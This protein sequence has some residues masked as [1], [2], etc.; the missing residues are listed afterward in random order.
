MAEKSTEEIDHICDWLGKL[1][2]EINIAFSARCALRIAPNL[3]AVVNS[4]STATVLLPFFR[5]TLT[6]TVAAIQPTIELGM[7]AF[8]ASEGPKGVFEVSASNAAKAAR[9]AALAASETP[10]DRNNFLVA[11]SAVRTDAEF[12]MVNPKNNS[13][14]SVSKNEEIAFRGI[15]KAEHALLLPLWLD[16]QVPNRIANN[17]RTLRQKLLDLN[18]NWEFWIDWYERH[19]DGRPQNWELLR[20]IALIPNEDWENGMLHWN[21]IIKDQRGDVITDMGGE[22]ILDQRAEESWK[23]GAMHVNALIAKIVAASRIREIVNETPNAETIRRN[24]ESNLWEAIP[25]PIEFVSRVE[26]AVEKIEDSLNDIEMDRTSNEP[27]PLDK[28]IRRLRRTTQEYRNK[29]LRMHDDF[30][31]A[32]F[33]IHE[34]IQSGA[35]N[36]SRDLNNLLSD[37]ATGILD[38]RTEPEVNKAIISRQKRKFSLSQRNAVEKLEDLVRENAKESVPSLAQTLS[39]N[40]EL[41]RRPLSAI[42]I[43]KG[44]ASEGRTIAAYE[45]VSINARIG[46]EKIKEL[47]KDSASSSLASNVIET[48]GKINKLGKGAEMAYSWYQPL[49]DL[50]TSILPPS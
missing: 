32:A 27:S 35:L 45:T 44:E 17:W 42:E 49:I 10:L 37:L 8:L 22:P 50:F 21:S 4:N 26:N 6:A 28:E 3:V 48:A 15:K 40:Y 31:K 11:Q 39:A 13:S 12:H 25:D 1:P 9:F 5:S 23:P 29:P 19:L 24:P 43:E 16:H 34:D 30:E 38:L 33:N 20:R 2:K 36:A 41:M 7:A 18:E 14:N 47:E 46:A